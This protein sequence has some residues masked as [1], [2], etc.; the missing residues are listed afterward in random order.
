MQIQ[1]HPYIVTYIESR[2][3][4]GITLD[5]FFRTKK[6]LETHYLNNIRFTHS[7]VC[8]KRLKAL[9]YKLESDKLFNVL[10]H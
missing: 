9:I 8:V 6:D 1:G 7:L 5:M 2:L 3:D 10:L 4:N